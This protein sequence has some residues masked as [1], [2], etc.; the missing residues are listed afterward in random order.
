MPSPTEDEVAVDP[1]DFSK[2]EVNA[3]LTPDEKM[4]I[5][6]QMLRIRRFEQV[7]LKYY[8]QGAMGGFLHLYIG[9]EAVAVERFPFLGK[10]TMSSRPTATTATP[11]P[12]AWE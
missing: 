7:S 4:G 6:R 5:L 2:A 1:V 10:T 8:N 9:Q 3:N 11:S 12:S